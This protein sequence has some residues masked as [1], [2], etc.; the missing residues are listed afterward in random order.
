MDNIYFVKISD[1]NWVQCYERGKA[2]NVFSLALVPKKLVVTS[3]FADTQQFAS[4]DEAKKVATA[5]G[6]TFYAPQGG[7]Q[8]VK[9][10]QQL[11]YSRRKSLMKE[12][13]K[14]LFSLM[15]QQ[16]YKLEDGSRIRWYLKLKNNGPLVVAHK[17]VR[18]PYEEY[19]GFDD[20]ASVTDIG[21][22]TAF[23]KKDAEFICGGFNACQ[24]NGFHSENVV[25]VVD[26]R[27][28]VQ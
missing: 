15:G 20:F 16:T 24:L 10:D 3:L 17:Q 11:I 14:A 13:T 19:F 12:Q 27:K 21:E 23:T 22:A 2:D 25:K 26:R 1:K 7:V 9:T 5:F 18:D 8:P 4:Y 6:G 28:I